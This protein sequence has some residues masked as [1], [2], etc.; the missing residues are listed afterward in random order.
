MCRMYNKVKGEQVVSVNLTAK[1]N[2]ILIS[3]KRHVVWLDHKH[4]YTRNVNY[5]YHV[6]K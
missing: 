4:M 1:A 3:D 6:K 2:D 5:R